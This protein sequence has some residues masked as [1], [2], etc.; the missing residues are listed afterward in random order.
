MR[1][2]A[3]SIVTGNPA[4]E[5]FK[6][7]PMQ[8][9]NDRENESRR[10]YAMM[11]GNSVDQVGLIYLNEAKRIG[12]SVDG[13]IDDNG[14]LELKNP[15]LETHIGYVLDGG[16][17]NAYVKQV[18]SQLWV[19]GGDYCDFASYHPD[20]F[21]MLHRFRVERD[22][23]MIKTIKEATYTFIGELDVLVEKMRAQQ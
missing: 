7:G 13:L 3:N 22:E 21:K 9:G 8:E 6:S 17:P 5:G 4:P 18:Q 10:F 11:S 20:A 19:T 16:L 2:L 14:N 12:A 15:N 1:R 23:L